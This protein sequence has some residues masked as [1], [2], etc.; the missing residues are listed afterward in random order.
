MTSLLSFICFLLIRILG[1][2]FFGNQFWYYFFIFKLI[3]IL[4]RLGLCHFIIY[5][6]FRL[7]H[8]WV[9]ATVVENIFMDSILCLNYFFVYQLFRLLLYKTTCWGR[10][11]FEISISEMVDCFIEFCV[12]N[13]MRLFFALFV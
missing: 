9:Y 10:V 4:D 5:V 3:H 8:I 7:N 6:G 1:G 13:T 11:F 12:C 2:R